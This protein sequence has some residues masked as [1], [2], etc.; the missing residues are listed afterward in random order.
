MIE[1]KKINPE[2]IQ[3][4]EFKLVKGQI[5]SPFEFQSQNIVSFNYKVDLRTGINLEEKLIRADLL[6]DV[7]TVS[8]EKAE[9]ASAS[10]HFVFIYYFAHIQDHTKLD[11]DLVDWNPYLANAYLSCE[12]LKLVV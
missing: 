1:K 8:K 7:S 2:E 6:T 12:K 9:E 4:R 10:Y 3:I 5:D 11:K